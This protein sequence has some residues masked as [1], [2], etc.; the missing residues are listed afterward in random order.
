V[1]RVDEVLHGLGVQFAWGHG[2]IVHARGSA[3]SP[4]HDAARCKFVDELAWRVNRGNRRATNIFIQENAY[5]T[6]AEKVDFGNWARPGNRCWR[7]MPGKSISEIGLGV[8]V[9]SR[10]STT[11]PRGG[12][13]PLLTNVSH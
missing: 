6:D 8:G 13:D 10:R 5:S 1:Q 12:V 9:I 2:A 3:S 7:S 11:P 4:L